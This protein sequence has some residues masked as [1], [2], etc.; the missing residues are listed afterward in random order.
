MLF[1]VHLNYTGCYSM[2]EKTRPQ[3][4][5][6]LFEKR[7][8]KSQLSQTSLKLNNSVVYSLQCATE[9]YA[10]EKQIP[11]L[12]VSQRFMVAV[13]KSRIGIFFNISF[14]P[15]II[16]G[17]ES[18]KEIS[19]IS[20]SSLFILPPHISGFIHIKIIKLKVEFKKFHSIFNL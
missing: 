6:H 8:D 17:K 18:P 5:T 1:Y 13:T 19:L 10:S 14:P 9:N 11:K 4:T 20:L 15:K 7:M 12:S 16:Y 2:F 3:N